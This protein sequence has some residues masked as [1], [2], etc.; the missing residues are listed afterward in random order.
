MAVKYIDARGEEEWRDITRLFVHW[1]KV[2]VVGL[3]SFGFSEDDSVKHGSRRYV[4]LF[5]PDRHGENLSLFEAWAET[6]DRIYGE[7]VGHSVIF[8]DGA[9]ALVAETARGRANL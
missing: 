1:L 6:T 3:E 9:R 5:I 4:A 7:L 8:S 2:N